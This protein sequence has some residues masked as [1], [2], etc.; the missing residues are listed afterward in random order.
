MTY[1]INQSPQFLTTTYD[2]KLGLGP[3]GPADNL[4]NISYSV[5]GAV[6]LDS[7]GNVSALNAAAIPSPPADAYPV[8]ITVDIHFDS[9]TVIA[10]G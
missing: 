9:G 1:F 3:C 10:T 2:L 5:A 4:Q 8:T 6:D 7:S